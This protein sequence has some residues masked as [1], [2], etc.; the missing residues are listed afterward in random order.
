MSPISRL[1]DSPIG[2]AG[3]HPVPAPAGAAEFA[4]LLKTPDVDAIAIARL[5]L[6][7]YREPYDRL[8]ARE[9]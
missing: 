5:I 6:V 7:L 1:K 9:N 2:P 3:D 4:T 8:S